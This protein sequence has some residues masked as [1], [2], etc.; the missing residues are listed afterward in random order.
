MGTHTCKNCGEVLPIKE[1]VREI[2][3]EV[4]VGEEA[5]WLRQWRNIGMIVVLITAIIAGTI[6]YSKKLSNDEMQILLDDPNVQIEILENPQE[7]EPMRK[8]TRPAKENSEK[9]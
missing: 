7:A 5:F 3:T 2:E 1:I 8:F 9:R 4:E 6:V